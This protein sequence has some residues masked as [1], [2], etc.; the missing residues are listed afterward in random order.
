M[1][2]E[3]IDS[4]DLIDFLKFKKKVTKNRGHRKK[5]IKVY[6]RDNR[7]FPRKNR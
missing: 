4:D 6:E 2:E 1:N 7:Y 5:W 3:N